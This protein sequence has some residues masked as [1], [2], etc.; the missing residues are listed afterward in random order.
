MKKIA[1]DDNKNQL[2]QQKHALDFEDAQE[3]LNGPCLVY[4]DIR[5]DYGEKRFI[6]IG[7]LHG[8]AVVLI[9]TK[10]EDIYRIISMRK[11]NEKEQKAYQNRLESIR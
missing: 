2:N 7:N 10:R 3:V 5:Y 8:R 11:A 4:E 9:Y 1:W 6:V